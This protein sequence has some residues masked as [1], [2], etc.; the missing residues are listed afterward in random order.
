[1][2]EREFVHP[3]I[4][5]AVPEIRSAMLAA[6]GLKDIEEVYAEIPAEIR[7]NGELDLPPALPAEGRLRRHLREL[8]AKNRACRET[9]SFLGGGC[10]QHEVPAVVDEIVNRSEF[11]TAY[12]G[13]NYSDLGKYQARFEFNSL[14]GELLSLDAV[15][16]PIYDWGSAAGLALRMAARITGRRTVLL[17]RTV[18]PQRLAQIR[19]LCQPEAM[20]NHIA[21]R[22]IDYDADSGLLD[23]DALAAAMTDDIAAVYFENPAY[24]GFI[25]SRARKIADLAHRRG[26]LCIA[27]VDPISLG[28]LAPPG[29][30]GADIAVGDLQPLGMHML[31]GG[32]QSGFI[33]FRDEETY[34]AECP[35]AVYSILETVNP[36]EYAFA[37]VQAERTSYG[38]RD[39]GKDWVGTASGL[40]TIG[41]AVYLALMGPRGMTEVGQTICRN[42]AYAQKLVAA[43]PGVSVR[44]PAGNF[45]E[46]VLDFTKTGKKVSEINH[47]LLERGIYGGH[48]LS[49][50]FPELGQTALY[51]V[52]ECHS[53][54]DLQRLAD[55][56]KEVT[57]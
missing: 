6:V 33:A 17:P 39:Q 1:M 55:T 32:G 29:E 8:L 35:L 24:L 14:M 34:V 36:G 4:P 2:G 25:E 46:F 12:C 5:N 47:A 57:A 41:A 53:A 38:L 21:L 7:F 26:A 11:L 42:A 23:L 13:A 19:T 9:L 18:S 15:S 28:L 27:G 51:C 54:A 52:T 10:W 37:E 20:D 50:E 3:Y 40:W 48:D 43:I 30:Y 16:E 22:L 31:C 49:V 56:L 45:K 44:F